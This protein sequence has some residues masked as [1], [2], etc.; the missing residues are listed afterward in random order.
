M[1]EFP[2]GY[3]FFPTEEELLGFYLQNK[4]EN[5]REDDMERIMPVVDVYSV[6]PWKLPGKWLSQFK[7]PCFY[8]YRCPI[9][10]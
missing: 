5:R 8:I 9:L 4:L 6:D 2:P 1:N 3:R 7:L 10:I